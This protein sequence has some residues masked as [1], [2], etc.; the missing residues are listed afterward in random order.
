MTRSIHTGASRRSFLR[1]VGG[2]AASAAIPQHGLPLVT[3]LAGMAALASQSSHAA[4][5]SGYKALVCLY[6]NGGSDSH[7]WVVPTDATGYAEYVR[8]RG[9]LAWAADR[10]QGITVTGQAG[11]RSFGMPT[12]LTPLRSWYEA[13]QAAILANV[14]P[15]VRPISKAEYSAGVSV[16]AKLFSHNDQASTWQSLAPEGA[17]SGWGGRM[18]DI[19]M[20]ANAHP[21][22]TAVSASGN[23]V[24]LSGSSVSQYQVGVEGP[25][26]ASAIGSAN[27][28]GSTSAGSA[29][30]RAYAAA[31]SDRIQMEYARVMQRG[32]SANAALQGAL[33]GVNVPAIPSTAVAQVNAAS[34]TLDKLN[35]ARQLRMV[36]QI[37]AA[38]QVLGMKRQVFMVQMGGFDTHANQMRDQPTQMAQVAQSINYFMAALNSLGLQNSVTLFTA[39]DFGR[40]LLSNGDGSD[41]GWGSHHFVAG[42][43]VRGGAMYGQFPSTALGTADDI[44]SGRLLPTMAVSQMAGSMAA[45]MGLNASEQMQVLPS[46]ANFSGQPA[47]MKV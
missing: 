41:H 27:L 28:F 23:A 22:F 31:S 2:L 10:L 6:M 42:G 14:G 9:E 17:P 1:A 47:F 40:T 36:L 26:S 29:L 38:N 37:I 5:T 46:L 32:L 25:V 4:T 30:Q 39:S 24:F 33:T 45:W 15:L 19:L 43:A 7:N 34:T 13:G 11:G 18:G 3:G 21:V 16:P 8:S 35:L 44:G 20:S 12:E